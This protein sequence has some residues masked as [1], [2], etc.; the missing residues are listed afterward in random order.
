[1]TLDLDPRLN[2]YRRDL[3]DERLKDKVK[4]PR[5]VAG[6]LHQASQPVTGLKAKPDATLGLEN[7]V[8][9]GESVRVFD[10]SNG[11]AWVQLLRDGYVGYMHAAA[12]SRQVHTTTHRVSALGTFVY[13]SPDIKS[14]P[15]MHI[16]MN[17]E[18]AVDG[19]QEQFLRLATG[20]W[21]VARHTV[22]LTRYALDFVAIAERFIG[23]PYL[24]GGRTRL[25][26]DCSGLLQIALEAAGQNCPRDSDMQQG[27]VGQEVFVS[28]E[29]D[30]LERGDLVFW[31]RHVGIMVDGIMLI[32]ANAH[33]M[34]VAVEPLPDAVQ[35]IARAGSPVTVVKR[36]AQ[37][38]V[39]A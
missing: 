14:A 26:L 10:E 37:R 17:S 5:Y 8:L 36:L 2:A 13:P 24:W 25:G 30:G 11:W 27:T 12:L 16:S 3:A 9:F 39:R 19:Q 22:D 1:M 21:V 31:P 28:S 34:A 15:S 6:E 32:H 33:H 35:R 38:A 29:L 23:T 7:E 4:V 20:G 18:L